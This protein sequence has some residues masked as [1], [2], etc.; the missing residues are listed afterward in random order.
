LAHDIDVTDGPGTT[1]ATSCRACG[2]KLRANARFCHA[3]SSPIAAAAGHA[4]YQASD[5]VVCRRRA[6][7]GYRAAVGAERLREI[8]IGLV[9]RATAAVQRYGGTVDRFTGDGSPALS[10]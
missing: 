6:L 7:D 2:T 5:R 9:N 10:G 3:C 4:E 1:A 8:M